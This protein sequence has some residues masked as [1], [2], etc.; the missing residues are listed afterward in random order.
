MNVAIRLFHTGFL[1]EYNHGISS[2]F[3]VQ[4][5][6]RVRSATSKNSGEHSGL[7]SQWLYEQLILRILQLVHLALVLIESVDTLNHTLIL[8]NI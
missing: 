1:I 7:W 5:N 4:S 8:L 2:G 3:E 6:P